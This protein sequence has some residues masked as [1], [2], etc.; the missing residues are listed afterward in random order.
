MCVERLILECCRHCWVLQLA[1]HTRVAFGEARR[2]G[3]T[4]ADTCSMSTDARS[5]L[6]ANYQIIFASAAAWFPVCNPA[7]N[8]P[9]HP[10]L[11][12]PGSEVL[13]CS[14]HV[15]SAMGRQGQQLCAPQRQNCGLQLL[16]PPERMHVPRRGGIRRRQCVC[17]GGGPV[18]R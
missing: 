8:P 6:A 15:A 9:H 14:G 1:Q 16:R 11:Q 3:R 4:G 12:L 5:C 7:P 10:L 18:G 17:N 13:L 2:L